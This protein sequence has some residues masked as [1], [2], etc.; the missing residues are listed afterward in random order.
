M[1]RVAMT[2]TGAIVRSYVGVL[3][4][5]VPIFL[6]AG[7]VRYWQGLLYVA[8]SL[9]GTTLNHALTPKG[10][11]LAVER[12]SK[13]SEGEAWDR[14]IL[15]VYFLV[16]LAGFAVAGLDSGRFGWTGTVSPL[17]AICGAV[18]MILG[19]LIFAIARGQNAFFSATVRIQKERGHAVCDTGLYRFV[20]HPG[21]V[22]ALVAQVAFP[23]VM[24]SF[25]A[26]VPAGIGA[27]L[28]VLRTVMEDRFLMK[29]LPGYAAYAEKTRWRLVPGIY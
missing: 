12:A 25:V 13:A 6:A 8:L 14:R 17:V 4:F 5:A 15:G 19:Q 23:L 7:R 18:L 22:G 24:E 29:E 2:R 20:R 9:F 28:M 16:N 21:Y 27:A 1:T 10:S 26:F 3:L 11:D